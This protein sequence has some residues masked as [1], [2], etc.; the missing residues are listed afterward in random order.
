MPKLSELIDLILTDLSK[1]YDGLPIQRY[2]SDCPK[3]ARGNEVQGNWMIARKE[4]ES[5]FTAIGVS[6][7]NLDD[8][9]SAWC[10]DNL[11]GLTVPDNKSNNQQALFKILLLFTQTQPNALRNASAK[12][13]TKHKAKTIVSAPTLANK[14]SVRIKN[15]EADVRPLAPAKST[16]IKKEPE[17]LMSGALGVTDGEQEHPPDPSP[18]PKALADISL[19]RKSRTTAEQANAS[20]WRPKIKTELDGLKIPMA[21]PAETPHRGQEPTSI[22]ERPSH[23][24]P[25]PLAM[26]PA[27]KQKDVRQSPISNEVL[28]ANLGLILEGR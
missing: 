19:K 7:Q 21:I 2:V 8:S 25:S 11:V 10:K 16:R 12:P 14:K 1:I 17:E 13:S 20:G 3:D 6:P 27:K 23:S 22:S 18:A 28:S 5:R 26:R 4:A 9:L 15:E 24:P